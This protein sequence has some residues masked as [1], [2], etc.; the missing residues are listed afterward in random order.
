MGGESFSRLFP[1]LHNLS[2]PHN[3]S[4]SSMV[5]SPSFP[6]DWDFRFFRNL[7]DRECIELSSLL[8]FLEGVCLRESVPDGRK[9]IAHSSGMFSCKSFFDIL[10]DD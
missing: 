1:R 10:V 8:S 5:S 3:A 2:L 9:W 6:I 4:I 7:N